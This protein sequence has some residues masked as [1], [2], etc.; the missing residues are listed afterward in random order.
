M[1]IH[2]IKIED[3][4]QENQKMLKLKNY[5]F[6]PYDYIIHYNEGK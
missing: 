5:M 4:T 6:Y 2:F 1:T 3:E